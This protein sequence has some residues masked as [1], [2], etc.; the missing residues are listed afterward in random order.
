MI[1]SN[2]MFDNG[3]LKIF[4]IKIGIIITVKKKLTK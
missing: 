4:L 3:N 1:E 2:F